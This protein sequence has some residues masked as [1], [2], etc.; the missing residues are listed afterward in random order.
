MVIKP[1]YK[2]Y[3]RTVGKLTKN[4]NEAKLVV[5]LGGQKAYVCIH[6]EDNDNERTNEGHDLHDGHDDRIDNRRDNGDNGS[7]LRI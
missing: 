1:A 7:G 5:V 2:I 3:W 6:T 4:C